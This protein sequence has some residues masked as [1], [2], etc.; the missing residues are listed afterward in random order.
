MKEKQ[1]WNALLPFPSKNLSG[2]GVLE[3]Q[4]EIVFGISSPGVKFK[5][6]L[7]PAFVQI[8]QLTDAQKSRFEKK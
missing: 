7:C 3:I 5:I 6:N 1:S 2:L 8:M 4:S